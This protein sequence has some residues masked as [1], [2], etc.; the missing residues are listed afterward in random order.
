[1]L[2]DP[3]SCKPAVM[4]ETDDWVAMASEYRAIAVLPG[5]E[6]AVVWEPAP[7][8]VYSWERQPV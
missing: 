3:I 4:A 6:D 1:V 7:A 2:R 8:T 5:A